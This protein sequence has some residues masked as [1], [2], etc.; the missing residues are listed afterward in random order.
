MEQ[1]DESE[2][3][4]ATEKV[5]LLQPRQLASSTEPKLGR[6]VPAGQLMQEDEP[7]IV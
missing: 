4:V 3:P 1:L 6:K 7:P 5:P 2:T